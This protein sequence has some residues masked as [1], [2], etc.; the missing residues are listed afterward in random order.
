MSYAS[1]PPPLHFSDENN[2]LSSRNPELAQTLINIDKSSA[3]QNQKI[4]SSNF[5]KQTQTKVLSVTA[6]TAAVVSIP[7]L[8]RTLSPA[9]RTF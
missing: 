3:Y 4:I 9:Q 7:V 2:R 5:Q 6:H 1:S 8:D